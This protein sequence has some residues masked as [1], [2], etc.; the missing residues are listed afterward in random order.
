M[1]LLVLGLQ[2]MFNS[3]GY[4]MCSSNVLH[5]IIIVIRLVLTRVLNGCTSIFHK[6]STQYSLTT[7]TTWFNNNNKWLWYGINALIR[8]DVDQS[9][10]NN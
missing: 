6:A 8:Y 4:Y 5:I 1:V 9:E 2:C 10:Y 7:I 3:T